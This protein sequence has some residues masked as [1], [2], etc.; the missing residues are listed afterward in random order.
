VSFRS[1]TANV[2]RV[3]MGD[4]LTINFDKMNTLRKEYCDEKNI[5]MG[6]DNEFDYIRWL[7]AKIQALRIHDVVGRS[8]QYCGC[9]L[10]GSFDEENELPDDLQVYLYWH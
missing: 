3:C 6:L 5:P 1:I 10:K 7:E 8:E 9:N 2:P 4:L